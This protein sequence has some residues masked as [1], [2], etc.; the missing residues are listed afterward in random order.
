MTVLTKSMRKRVEEVL[1]KG[2][3]VG[4]GRGQEGTKLLKMDVGWGDYSQWW[5][6]KVGGTIWKHRIEN[7]A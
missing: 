2:T 7:L 6:R 3:Q 4:L 5:T 1:W